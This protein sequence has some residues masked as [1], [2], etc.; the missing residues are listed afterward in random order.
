MKPWILA[1]ALA[2]FSSPAFAADKAEGDWLPQSG[3]AKIRVAPCKAGDARM[4]GTV[5]WLKRPTGADGTP[6]RDSRN[7][8]PKLATRPVIGLT[9]LRDFKSSTP[10]RWEGGKVYD[11][12]TGKTYAG[13]MAINPNGTLKVEGCVTVVCRA[14]TWTRAN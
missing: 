6:V 3:A 1:T 9:L 8:D 14:Q 11:P 2:V 4:C 13:K 12:N 5:I 10:G 7:P